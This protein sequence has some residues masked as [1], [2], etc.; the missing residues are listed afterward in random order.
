MKS[1]RP[2]L[3]LSVEW[4]MVEH[5]HL[6]NKRLAHLKKIYRFSKTNLEP[7]ICYFLRRIN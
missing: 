7:W 4:M 1:A 6:R 5:I 2:L 3:R